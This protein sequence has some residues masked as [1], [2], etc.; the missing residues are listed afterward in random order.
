MSG[1]VKGGEMISWPVCHPQFPLISEVLEK[2]F[3]FELAE[4]EQITLGT[5]PER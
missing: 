4:F 1:K 5:D 2:E 3:L